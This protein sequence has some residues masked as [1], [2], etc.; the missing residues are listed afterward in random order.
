[1]VLGAGLQPQW[2]DDGGVALRGL[3]TPYGAL[4]YDLKRDGSKVTWTI[5]AGAHPPGGVILTWPLPQPPGATTVN[6]KPAQWQD[7]MLRVTALP[8]K[9]VVEIR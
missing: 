5:A 4:G 8:A 1:L 3:R 2:L 7:G 6:G 9:V